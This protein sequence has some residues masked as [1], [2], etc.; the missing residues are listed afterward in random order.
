MTKKLLFIFGTRPEAIKMAPVVQAFKNLNAHFIPLVI[1]TAQHRQMLDQV[2]SLFNIKPDYDLDIMLHDQS[3]S[4]ITISALK[5]IED[6]LKKENPHLVFVQGDT[7]TTFV[8]ALAAFYQKIPVA[9]IEA[10]LRTYNKSQPYPEE[11]NRTLTSA[12]T[13]FHFAPTE[14]AKKNLL[15]EGI[16][17]KK[18]WVTGNTVIDALL[19]VEKKTYSFT[20][21]LEKIFNR[22]DIRFLLVTAHRRENHGGPLENIC[23]ALLEII[24]KYKDVE[25]VYP[26]H[27][28]PRVRKTIF[29]LLGN[30]QRIHLLPPLD[31]EPFVQA[32][33]KSYLILTDS[34]GVQ[35]EAPSLGKPILVLRQTTERPEAVEAGTVNLVG[36]D[37][38][39]IVEMVEILLTD[40]NSYQ[41][42]AQAINPYGDGKATNR[43]V[44]VIRQQII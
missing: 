10:G 20:N 22:K 42:M 33:A 38:I 2:L 35:E 43:I 15:Q 25:V 31:Y 24:K 41:K 21:G 9:H 5:G 14:G 27:L 30:H 4:D 34:G 8:G 44:K 13:D 7:T 39:K 28:S 40:K 37:F 19:H 23:K 6:I 3:L 11:M 1:V 36:T 32:M 12:L 26:V 17:P 18:I 16:H 29:P